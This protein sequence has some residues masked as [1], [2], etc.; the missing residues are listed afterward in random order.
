MTKIYDDPFEAFAAVNQDA[1]TPLR[2]IIES[3][4]QNYLLLTTEEQG[5]VTGLQANLDLGFSVTR[6]DAE[7]LLRIQRA[8]IERAHHAAGR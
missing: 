4:G 5:F 7:K 2:T 3:I 6:K 1:S 8:A